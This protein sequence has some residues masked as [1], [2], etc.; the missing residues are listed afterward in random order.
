MNQC[1]MPPETT[2][3]LRNMSAVRCFVFLALLYIGT[4]LLCR[5]T[6]TL[7]FSKYEGEISFPYQG[8]EMIDPL[9]A[10]TAFNNSTGVENKMISRLLVC[11]YYP[12]AM[13][14]VILMEK[15][16]IPLLLN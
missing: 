5:A 10:K 4:Y 2:P 15:D 12:I 7:Y 3:N 1:N 14:E 8:E 16:V 9:Y 11:V 6:S 13:T